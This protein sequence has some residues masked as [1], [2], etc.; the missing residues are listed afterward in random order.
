MKVEVI[1]EE[2]SPMLSRTEYVFKLTFEGPTP[3]NEQV[4]EV[5]KKYFKE[6]HDRIAI[7][8]IQNIYGRT[9]AMVNVYYY[10]DV[11]TFKR[12]EPQ[13]KKKEEEN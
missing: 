12:L 7:K 8:K 1:K 6:G 13:P 4:M 10:D 2:K 11:E 3:S 9:E 5:M